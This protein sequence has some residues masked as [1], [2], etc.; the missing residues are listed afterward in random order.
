MNDRTKVIIAVF[1]VLISAVSINFDITGN[2]VREESIIGVNPKTIEN[3]GVISIEIKPGIKGVDQ[4]LQ[5]YRD[6]GL[7]IAHLS[8]R[9]CKYSKCYD[10]VTINKRID[11]LDLSKDHRMYIEVYDFGSDRPIRIYFNVESDE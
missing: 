6:N 2:V 1:I 8:T 11:G 3:N 10:D 5:F 7:R 9:V 4:S